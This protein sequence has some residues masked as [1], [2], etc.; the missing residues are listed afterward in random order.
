M[1]SRGRDQTWDFG[2][3]FGGPTL[4]QGRARV[5]P[6]G[7]ATVGHSSKRSFLC[8]LVADFQSNLV[9][10]NRIGCKNFV[11]TFITKLDWP[12]NRT[13]ACSAILQSAAARLAFHHTLRVWFRAFLR[14]VEIN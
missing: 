9:I 5:Q 8:A 10:A 7:T 13:R 4:Q 12:Q 1:H 14:K 11:V 6:G 2:V 3:D